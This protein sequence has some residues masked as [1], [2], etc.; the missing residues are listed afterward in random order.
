MT[1]TN[2]LNFQ[3]LRNALATESPP[4][5]DVNTS[6]EQPSYLGLWGLESLA[7]RGRE[8]SQDTVVSD[9]SRCD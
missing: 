6:L 9:Q 1:V 7:V 8:A 3:W 5:R 2:I 4:D